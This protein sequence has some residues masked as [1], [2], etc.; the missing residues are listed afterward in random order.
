MLF[1]L[2]FNPKCD[3]LFVQLYGPGVNPIL[4]TIEHFMAQNAHFHLTFNPS[5][6]KE[7]A[8]NNLYANNVQTLYRIDACVV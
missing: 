2:L 5:K 1:E 4:I 6:H 3:E 7:N 8:T